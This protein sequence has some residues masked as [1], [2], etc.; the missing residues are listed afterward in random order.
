MQRDAVHRG[1]HAVFADAVMDVTA[2][3]IVRGDRGWSG[4]SGCCWN[5]SGR[6]IRRAFPADAVDHFKRHFGR[7]AGGDFGSL[8]KLLLVGLIPARDWPGRSPR[9]RRSNSARISLSASA[10]RFP[11]LAVLDRTKAGNAPGVENV[12]GHLERLFVPAERLA[13]AGD[14]LVAERR[15]VRLGVRPCWARR[16]RSRSCRRSVSA[17]R[18]P[19][20]ARWPQRWRRGRAR[21]CDIVFQPDA[22][23]RA[24]WSVESVSETRAVDGDRIVVPE[25]DQ[26]V[27]LEVAGERDRFLADAFHQ[28]AVAGE[29]IG[30][31][32]D[33]IGAEISGKLAFGDR[34]ADGIGKALAERAG[35]RL[36]ACGVAIFRMAGGF[37]PSWRKFLI[38]SSVMSS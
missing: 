18:W 22:S 37:E 35:G 23:K 19:R 24:C 33:Q 27:E 3:E 12:G 14:F 29:H 30:V 8:R 34:H 2:G 13:G 20:R 38:S 7:L 15:A 6:Q 31:V 16:S 25:D 17:G 28:A 21:R 32:I 10:R 11:G 9:M 36:D 26:L 5:R 1:G 4:W